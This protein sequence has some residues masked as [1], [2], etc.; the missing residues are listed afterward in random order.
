MRARRDAVPGSTGCQP[1]AFGGLAE[2]PLARSAIIDASAIS[3]SGSRQAAANYRLAACA[4]QKQKRQ[5]CWFVVAFALLLLS[6]SSMLARSQVV[7]LALPT[8]NDALFRGGGPEFYQYIER[9][10]KGVKSTP[11]EGGQYGFVRDPVETAAGIV[12]TRFH[13]GIDIRALQ[14]DARGEPL[15]EVRA[16]ADGKVVHTNPVAGYSNYG[17]YIVIEHSW[18]GSNYYSLYGHLSSIEV[19]PGQ[20]VQKGDRIAVMGYTGAGLNRARAHLHLE[21]NL[22]LSHQFEAWH[23]AFIKNDPNHNG[24]YNGLNLTGLDI[25]RLFLA[26]RK[27]PS[28]TIPEFLKDE[29]VFYKV[30]VP[31]SSHFELI[32]LYPWM[33]QG[34]PGIK[35]SSWEVSFA[36]SGVPLKVQPSDK[37]VTEPELTYVKE[38]PVDYSHLTRGEITGRGGRAHLTENG[39]QLMR[40]LTYPD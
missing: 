13:E 10:Y 9:D 5:R 21:L 1:V 28:L 31:K 12:Y 29:E 11:W 23:D 36:R 20:R 8:D 15:D 4:P 26:L 30:T 38:S 22:M 40:L 14:R 37:Q 25:A 6:N 32:K 19:K 18:D 7:D 16:I 24:I 27:N 39:K 34:S 3:C 17:K 35:T 2:C 33:L